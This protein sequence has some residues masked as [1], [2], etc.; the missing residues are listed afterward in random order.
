MRLAFASFGINT[1]VLSVV[2]SVFMAGLALGSWGGG[3]LTSWASRSAAFSPLVLYAA[4]EALIGVGGFCVPRLFD[5]GSSSLLPLGAADTT[6]YLFWSAVA[7]A[8]AL[9]PWCLCMG[10]TFPFMMAYLQGTS[11]SSNSF[12]YLYTAN[13]FGAMT[14][15][16]VTAGILIECLGFQGSLHLAAALNITIALAAF[17]AFFSRSAPKPFPIPRILFRSRQTGLRPPAILFITGFMSMGLEVLWTRDFSLVLKTQVYSF[18]ALL[19]TYLFSTFLGAWVYRRFGGRWILSTASLAGGAFVFSLGSVVFDDP[20]INHSIAGVLLSI[21]PFCAALGYLTPQILDRFSAGDPAKAGR[22]YGLNVLGCILGPLAA[23][24]LLLPALGV[25]SSI[26]LLSV[27]LIPFFLKDA[28]VSWSWRFSKILTA[29]FGL[30][31]LG[32]SLGWSVDY[33]EGFSLGP[34]TVTHRDYAATVI[35]FG[36]GMRKFLLVNGIGI[37]QLCQ[38][39]KD[40][41]H[42]PLVFFPHQPKS[43]LGICFGMGTTFRSLTSWGLET[44]HVELA[45]GVLKAFDY[46]FD[47][48][49]RV[50][51][52]PQTRLVVDDGRRFLK[53]TSALYDLITVDPPPPLEAAGSSLLYS[54]EFYDL[55]KKHLSPDGLFQQWI[56]NADIDVWKAVVNS[57][58]FSFPFIRVFPDRMGI[59]FVASLSPIPRLTAKQMAAKLPPSA[60]R[61]FMEWAPAPSAENYFQTILSHE[62]PL[63]Y[64]LDPQM[65]ILLTDNRP[66]NEYYLLRWFRAWL[67]K[68]TA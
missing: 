50:L 27:P 37:T 56:P 44:T 62:V 52:L 59:H 15:T 66:Y 64:L 11:R 61:D 36:R 6:L 31:L 18:A 19:F 9:L 29:A 21:V 48:A 2:L 46:Y 33:E 41:A 42:L 67:I 16:A 14:G 39:T 23:A 40:M 13:L 22:A 30:T 43:V 1:P 4:A 12:S 28:M 3:R 38:A 10:A 5:W 65:T 58:R 54:V 68:I 47:D 34:G 63:S 8:L 20:R 17:A 55:V 32:A 49:D 24:Y 60:M 51:A 57:L 25:R 35:S 45:P 26:I 7:L 53:R